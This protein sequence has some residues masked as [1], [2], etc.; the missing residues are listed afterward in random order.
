[1]MANSEECYFCGH[2][3]YVLER[4]SAEGKF[5]HRS[6]FTCH[7]CGITLRLGGYTFDENTGQEKLPAVMSGSQKNQTH[8]CGVSLPASRRNVK[9]KVVY[10]VGA[11]VGKSGKNCS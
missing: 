9:S 8:S 6:C 4:I 10:S 3:V 11:T 5:F 2:R 7:K 1:M